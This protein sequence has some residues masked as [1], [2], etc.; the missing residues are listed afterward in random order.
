MAILA[1]NIGIKP[2][3][4]EQINYY[5]PTYEPSLYASK[6]IAAHDFKGKQ[7]LNI[8]EELKALIKFNSGGS[9]YKK[10]LH[11]VITKD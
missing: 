6:V 8:W 1:L 11:D 9:V 4:I 5:A 7:L 2:M 10:Y 3:H